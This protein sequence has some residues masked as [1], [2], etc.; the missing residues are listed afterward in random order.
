MGMRVLLKNAAPGLIVL[1]VAAMLIGVCVTRPVAI[2]FTPTPSSTTSQ[3]QETAI[4]GPVGL[5]R[6]ATFPNF[7]IGS[8]ELDFESAGVQNEIE[9]VKKLWA[10][11]RSDHRMDALLLIGS[12][13]RLPLRRS[14]QSQFDANVG[15]ARARADAVKSRLL[16]ATQSLPVSDQIRESDILVLVSG[17]GQTPVPN[18]NPSVDRLPIGFSEDRKVD[19]WALWGLRQTPAIT[20]PQ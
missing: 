11:S 2:E 17:P 9:R 12:T 20:R 13:D 14:L 4:T 15:L 1:V 19:V 10:E 5:Q 7:K 6:L 3:A 8:A 16:E 18:P